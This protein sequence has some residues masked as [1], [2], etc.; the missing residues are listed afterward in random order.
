[1]RQP[2]R[3]PSVCNAPARD[4]I[5]AGRRFHVGLTQGEAVQVGAAH[6]GEQQRVGLAGNLR[7]KPVVSICIGYPCPLTL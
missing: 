7:M 5:R 4:E 6:G 3:N 2:V 1:M